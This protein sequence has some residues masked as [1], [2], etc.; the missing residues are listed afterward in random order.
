VALS[1]CPL[2]LVG[3]RRRFLFNP[4][5]LGYPYPAAVFSPG[6]SRPKKPD[7]FSVFLFFKGG[8]SLFLQPLLGQNR[9]QGVKP[10]HPVQNIFLLSSVG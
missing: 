6:R 7:I 4:L 3:H 9:R 1:F 8:F 5:P 10:Q 2:P